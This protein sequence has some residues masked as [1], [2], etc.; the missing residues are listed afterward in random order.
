MPVGTAGTVKAMT[1]DAVRATGAD[2]VL[3]NTYHLM[4]RPGAERVAA[5]RRAAPLHGLA[6]PDPDRFRRL[7]GHVAGQAAQARRGRRHLPVA[8]RRLAAPPDAG[9]L[10]RNPAP[11]GRHHHHGARRVHAV[12][13]HAGRG[14]ASHGAVDALGGA[15]ARGVRAAARLRAVRHRAG[16]RL[17]GAARA[18]PSRRCCDIG[19]DGYAVGGL[20]VGE[21]QAAM[22]ADARRHRAAPAGGPRR[23]T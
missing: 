5:A 6:R 2:I 15:L 13:R 7:P 18:R 16:Q 14:R 4:L 17:S 23:A 21:G 12:P 22:F 20:A 8:S 1:A 10:D 19:F 9:A 3:G 11:A